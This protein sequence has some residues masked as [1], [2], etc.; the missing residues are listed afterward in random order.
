[1]SSTNPTQHNSSIRM[2]DRASERRRRPGHS[3]TRKPTSFMRHTSTISLPSPKPK[4]I[5]F[6]PPSTGLLSIFRLP[7]PPYRAKTPARSLPKPCQASAYGAHTPIGRLS[8]LV[9]WSWKKLEEADWN[10]R[11]K[12]LTGRKGEEASKTEGGGGR[13]TEEEEWGAANQE[14]R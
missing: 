10:G 6:R 5:S 13:K 11:G 8:N 2:S 12:K 4:K 7:L 1:M 14:P 9:E 3:Q